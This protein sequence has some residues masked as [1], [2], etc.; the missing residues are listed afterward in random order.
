MQGIEHLKNIPLF[1]SIS[2]TELPA[3][4][5]ILKTV[6]IKK[7]ETI[8]SEGE[9]G[10]CLYII[11]EGQARVIAEL[12]GGEQITLSYLGSG[13]Y[14]G[15]MALIT[16]DPRSAT[17]LAEEEGTLWQID[18]KDFDAL[19][20]NNPAITLSMTHMLSQ[21]LSLANK[22][23]ESSERYYK[24]R[25]SPKGNLSET[26]LIKLLKYAEENSLSGQL[27]VKHEEQE[28]IFHFKKGQLDILEFEG[29]NEDEAMDE[30]LDWPEGAFIIQPDVYKIPSETVQPTPDKLLSDNLLI[31]ILEKYLTEKIKSFI[32]YSGARPVQLA[33][34]TSV[35]KFSKYFDVAS[36]IEINTEP[37]LKIQILSD[38]WTEKHTLFL[39]VL[40]RDLVSSMD[41]DLIGMAFWKL[42]SAD[43]QINKILEENQFFLYYDQA[44]DFISE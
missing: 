24:Q 26:D 17:V 12:D 15:E 38:I 37:A 21:R 3:L 8:I 43:P 30:L 42:H 27:I 40:M 10:D 31:S 20:M 29:K 6:P 1:H 36:Q 25:I 14:F 9:V 34:N 13:D 11:K 2:E 16:G 4:R 41:R 39:A 19:L 35:H 33:I 32:K 22:A 23:R 18:K 7:G 28:A 5:S 44:A